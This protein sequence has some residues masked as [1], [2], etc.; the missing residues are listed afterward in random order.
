MVML[1]LSGT[2]CAVSYSILLCGYVSMD[3]RI[4]PAA[5]SA[6][7]AIADALARPPINFIHYVIPFSMLKL[8]QS[9]RKIGNLIY[10][11]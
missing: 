6:N 10:H 4:I 5:E 3:G 2:L 1:Q 7:T 11:H 9:L 8:F